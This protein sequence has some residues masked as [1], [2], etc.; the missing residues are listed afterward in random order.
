MANHEQLDV[1]KQG[2]EAWKEWRGKN[3]DVQ[4]D[5]NDAH[6]SGANLVDAYLT[7]AELK[8]AKLS[9]ADL[10]GADL[11]AADLSDADLS[12]AL[13]TGTDLRGAELVDANLKGAI[14]INAILSEADLSEAHLGGAHVM[15]TFFGDVDLS[16]VKGLETVKHYGPSTIGINTIISS[17]GKIPEI[18]LRDAG[19]PDS[20]I[21]VIPSLVGSLKP[22]DYYSCFISYS[23]KDEA[24]AKRLYADLRSNNVRCWFAP[25][26]M[27]WGERIRTGIDEAIHIHDKLLLVLSKSSIASGW[28]EHEVK[29]ARAREK[30]ENKP[31]LFPVRVDKAIFDC[32]FDWATE[33]RHERNIGDF[34]R[35]KNHD[36]YQKAFTRLLRDLKAEAEQAELGFG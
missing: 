15:G 2:V 12:D 30:K 8:G 13:L 7:F 21:E 9:S 35:W 19:V 10:T 22:I 32:P 17:Q 27:K 36:D 25:E 31:I 1:L 34:T 26:D 4:I 3:P 6:L 23:S 28:I 20:I 5:L 11:S 18:F 29:T 16:L 24:L 14:L 33:I